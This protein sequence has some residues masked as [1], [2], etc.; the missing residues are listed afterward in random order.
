MLIIAPFGAKIGTTSEVYYVKN[1]KDS[2]INDEM[3]GIIRRLNEVIQ[4]SG[5]S[6]QVLSDKTGIA[7]SSLQRY[8]TGKIKRIPLNNIQK[9]ADACNASA[10]YIMNWEA[11]VE[12]QITISDEEMK[13]FLFGT[14]E[15]V[16]DEMLIK[17]KDY[18]LLLRKAEKVEL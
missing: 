4:S 18:A 12:T 5:L 9:I 10:R 6:Y 15:G 3:E 16:T 14:S 1:I 2:E 7:K 13:T 17:V 11:P 8:A